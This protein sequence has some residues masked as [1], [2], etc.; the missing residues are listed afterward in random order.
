MA[1]T[2]INAEIEVRPIDADL[3]R[4]GEPLTTEA[5]WRAGM[6]PTAQWIVGEVA[7]KML[8]GALCCLVSLTRKVS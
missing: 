6:D 8:G 3:F 7:H 5:A 4:V 2:S 1:Y